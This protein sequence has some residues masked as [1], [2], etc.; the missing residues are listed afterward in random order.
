MLDKLSQF[1]AFSYHEDFS[2]HPDIEESPK[3]M[4]GF[5]A[6]EVQ[7]VFPELTPPA[8]FNNNYLTID[9]TRMIPLLH[10]GVMET[11]D[12]VK[13]LKKRIKELEDRLDGLTR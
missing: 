9:Y 7:K 13:H 10:S 11:W 4:W 5:S 2:A 3:R 8:P 12:E 1:K 6:Q